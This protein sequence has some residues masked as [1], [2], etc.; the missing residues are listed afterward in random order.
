MNLFGTFSTYGFT[1]VIYIVWMGGIVYAFVNRQKHPRTSLL[2]G[3]AL[4]IMLLAY[5]PSTAV[6]F[7]MQSYVQSGLQGR[8][9][10]FTRLSSLSDGLALCTF[11]FKIAAWLLLFWALFDRKNVAER[12]I[13]NGHTD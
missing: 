10:A 3:G 13:V 1:L 6:S 8:Y 12:E 4:A 11:P 7:Y 9:E 2:A 5:L